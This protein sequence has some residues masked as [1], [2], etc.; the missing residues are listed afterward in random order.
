MVAVQQHAIFLEFI[1]VPTLCG[2]LRPGEPQTRPGTG[3]HT[4]R[5]MLS[6]LSPP[7][8]PAA[9]E[10]ARAP[11]QQR[12]SGAGPKHTNTSCG[13]RVCTPLIYPPSSF[14]T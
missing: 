1:P 11:G 4:Q 12:E 5:V 3:S 6:L 8:K 14:G 10:R 7:S 9:L 13:K 2:I